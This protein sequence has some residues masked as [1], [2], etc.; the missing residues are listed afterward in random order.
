[1]PPDND[2]RLETVEEVIRADST[3][4][5]AIRETASSKSNSLIEVVAVSL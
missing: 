1:M 2:E 5:A 4:N 3:S